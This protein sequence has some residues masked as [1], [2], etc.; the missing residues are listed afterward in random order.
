MGDSMEKVKKPSKDLR[1]QE[2]SELCQPLTM[3][4]DI[5][6]GSR[7]PDPSTLKLDGSGL[8][9]IPQPTTLPTDPLNYPDWLK[10]LILVQVSFLAALSILGV[11]ILNPV[12][13]P[14]AKEFN[15]T[16]VLATY[17][18]TVAL[19][20]GSL[21]PLIFTPIANVYG[22]RPAYLI[23]VL[24]GLGS[25]VGAATATSFSKLMV[26]RAFT[27]LGPSAAMGIGAGTVVDLFYGHQRGRAMG[28]FILLSTNGSHLAPIIGGYI[29]RDRSWRW[30]L[31]A[32]AMINGATFFIIL[33]FMPETLFDRPD[34]STKEIFADDK[35]KIDE[36]EDVSSPREAYRSPPMEFRTYIRRLWFW[37]LDRPASRQIKAKDFVVRPLSLLKYPSVVFPALYFSVTYG[38]ASIEPALT[39]ATLFTKIYKFDTAQNG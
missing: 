11:G 17:T 5:K 9:L 4:D 24:I 2:K 12:V 14:L 19:G 38:L 34:E 29:A 16:P 3:P 27:G 39:L 22:R 8:P 21:G 25:A 36:I 31:W 23:S 15:I 33:F 20:T 7:S 28:I 32:S 30:C 18:T 13:V 6:E 35:E 10:Y 26:A 37:D 1:S